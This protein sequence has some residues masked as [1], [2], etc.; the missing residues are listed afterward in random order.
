MGAIA[1][2][3]GLA[4]VIAG[5][6]IAIYWTIW[7]LMILVSDTQLYLINLQP[8]ISSKF[9]GVNQYFLDPVWIFRLPA[10][11]LIGGIT[12]IAYFIINTNQKIA[13]AARL[14]AAGVP[15]KRCSDELMFT[16]QINR[17]IQHTCCTLLTNIMYTIKVALFYL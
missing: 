14:K 15:L 1:R 4:L 5:V 2:L 9:S 8:F 10:I 6:F 13:E 12:F 3:F 11:A 17:F 16:L 7:V